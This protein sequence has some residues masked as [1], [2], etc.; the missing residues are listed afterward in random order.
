MYHFQLMRDMKA[1]IEFI[2]Q[3]FAT[4]LEK[5]T[6]SKRL[7][8]HVVAARVR[9]DMKIA[10]AD[11]KNAIIANYQQQLAASPSKSKR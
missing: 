2:T 10:M 9:M 1:A 6:P 5:K 3:Q 11:V 8:T 7:H 4:R